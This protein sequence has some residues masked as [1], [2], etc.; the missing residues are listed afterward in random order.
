MS[1]AMGIRDSKKII[2]I[3]DV[4]RFNSKGKIIPM[5]DI[6]R[7]SPEDKRPKREARKKKGQ[8][9]EVYPYEVEELRAMLKYFSERNQWL[10]YMMLTFG[11][12]MARRCSD[13]LELRWENVFNP[14]TG[15]FRNDLLEIVER[16]TD[17]LATPHINQA[18]KDAVTLYI[19]KTKCDPSH[20]SYKDY[21]FMQLSGNFKGKLLTEDG[22]LKAL[23]RAAKAVGIEKN[24]GT[25]SAR[26]TF[27]MMNRR[28]HPNDN[29][30]MELLREIFN[31][32][33]TS[34][35]SRYIGL[36]KEKTDSYYDDMGEFYREYVIGDKKIQFEVA[37]PMVT[38]D[39][40][41]LRTI[42]AS[43]YELGLT[44]AGSS[45]PMAAAMALNSVME[46]VEKFMK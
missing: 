14:S 10:H 43:A 32:R 20:N 26:K 4:P 1:E 2:N 15:Q 34:M 7:S 31:H 19:E 28:L 13:T 35:T 36:T 17:K 11:C 33:D 37:T 12:N 16:K 5:E 18:V 39:S 3:A 6:L 27:G 40:N 45:N 38:I 22:H 41:D 42:I 24:V 8:K 29:D 25:H 46:M 21:V 30:S 44:N 9:S 23:K